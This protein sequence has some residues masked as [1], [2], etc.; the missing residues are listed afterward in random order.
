MTKQQKAQAQLDSHF[1]TNPTITTLD[2]K[3]MLIKNWPEE[4]WTQQWVSGFMQSL[5]LEYTNDVTR[6][7]RIY[8]AP[9]T[10]TLQDLEGFVSDIEALGENITKTNLK[11]LVR[12]AGL[13]LGNFQ[14]LFNELSLQHLKGSYTSDNHKI[15]TRVPK[16]K[17]LS[18]S[19]GQLVDISTMAK[20]YLKN[21]ILRRVAD[22]GLD[23][24]SAL[25]DE[26]TE[27][28]KL[29]KAY[30]TYNLRQEVNKI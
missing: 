2:L 23:L 8:E 10:L 19:K 15:W 21:T 16:G 9:L 27:M 11:H 14:E 30:F 7:F 17:H 24:Y 18:Q 20:P 4:T 13:P 12:G 26:S 6:S 3:N 22:Y 5:D 28:H 25:T 1:L 29:L